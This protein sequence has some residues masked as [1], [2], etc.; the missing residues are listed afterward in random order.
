MNIFAIVLIVLGIFFIVSGILL[1]IRID[2]SYLPMLYIGLLLG[3]VGAGAFYLNGEYKKTQDRV[4]EASRVY[5]EQLANLEEKRSFVVKQANEL[6]NV[7]DSYIVTTLEKDK[8]EV[9]AGDL[10]LHAYVSG[11]E[12]LQVK[13]LEIGLLQSE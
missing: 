11:E 10:V 5:H 1:C 3:F 13:F 4:A 12:P 9:F 6:F 8:Y 2:D 7:E